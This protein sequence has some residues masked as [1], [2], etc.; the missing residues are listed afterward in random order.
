MNKLSGITLARTKKQTSWITSA[1]NITSITG[2]FLNTISLCV[3]TFTL[4]T[5]LNN[6][7]AE[8]TDLIDINVEMAKRDELIDIALTFH[9]LN[10][11]NNGNSNN[12]DENEYGNNKRKLRKGKSQNNALTNRG[13]CGNTISIGNINNIPNYNNIKVYFRKLESNKKAMKMMFIQQL[14][15]IMDLLQNTTVVLRFMI[16]LNIG[17]VVVLKDHAALNFAIFIS[18]FTLILKYQS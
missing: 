8:F 15:Q 1:P 14:V 5:N 6:M 9:N 18:T 11:K 7:A 4:I 17:N 13:R 12:N 16:I 3:A 10:L 2:I